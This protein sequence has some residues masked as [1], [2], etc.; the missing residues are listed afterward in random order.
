MSIPN[1]RTDLMTLAVIDKSHGWNWMMFLQVKLDN[2]VIIPTL[3][4]HVHEV[5][6]IIFRCYNN[7]T[8]N[9]HLAIISQES[10]CTW[11]TLMYNQNRW[12]RRWS[13][14]FHQDDEKIEVS[15]RAERLVCWHWQCQL[16]RLI[17]R[18]TSDPIW[19]YCQAVV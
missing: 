4:E 1:P 14:Q 13:S 16:L 18:P 12:K 2:Q 5:M 6:K 19:L 9:Q 17:C 15:Q 8:N 10:L 11:C 3:F 7:Q